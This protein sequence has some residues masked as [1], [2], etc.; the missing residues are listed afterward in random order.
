MKQSTD[1]QRFTQSI[2]SIAVV[3]DH[4]IA[5]YIDTFAITPQNII[6]REH[7]S[8]VGFFRIYDES[9]DGA[10]I[11]NFLTSVLK[12]AFYASTRRDTEKALELALAKINLALGELAQHNSAQWIGKVDGAICAFTQTTVCFSTCGSASIKL[13]RDDA[14]MEISTAPDATPDVLSTFNDI[15]CGPLKNEDVFIIASR[16]CGDVLSHDECQRACVRYSGKQREQFF[17]TALI[18]QTDGSCVHLVEITPARVEIARRDAAFDVNEENVTIPE[19]VFSATTFSEKPQQHSAQATA[20]TAP[21]A[22]HATATTP[23][24]IYLQGDEADTAQTP[25]GDILKEYTLQLRATLRRWTQSSRANI[26]TTYA[27]M[28]ARGA[29]HA[30]KT[31]AYTRTMSRKSF[32]IALA[33]ARRNAQKVRSTFTRT[34]IQHTDTD[35]EK[36]DTA[37]SRKNSTKTEYPKTTPT[38][39]Q[40]IALSQKNTTKLPSRQPRIKHSFTPHA[41]TQSTPAQ[42]DTTPQ[43]NLSALDHFFATTTNENDAPHTT[44]R[45]TNSAAITN[46]LGKITEHLGALVYATYMRIRIALRRIATTP[47]KPLLTK[48][49]PHPQRMIRTLRNLTLRQRIASLVIIAAIVLVPLALSHMTRKKSPTVVPVTTVAT[50]TPTENASITT[51]PTSTPIDRTHVIHK[52]ATTTTIISLRGELYAIAP[53]TITQITNAA[54]KRTFT[55]P[56]RYSDIAEAIA[57]DDLNLLFLRTTDNSIIS[58]TPLGAE[59]FV[60]NTITFPAGLTIDAMAAYRTYLYFFDSAANDIYRYPRVTGGFGAA[61]DWLGDDTTFSAPRAVAIDGTIYIANADGTIQSLFKRKKKAFPHINLQPA[62]VADSLFTS[63]EEAPLFI[64]DRATQRI[65]AVNKKNGAIVKNLTHTDF[66]TTQAFTV[67]ERLGI[68]SALLSDGTI[69]TYK[70]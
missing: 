16:E 3:R 39:P 41:T 65:I 31:I 17:R 23:G 28:H 50:E 48:V 5:P 44:A 68:I 1:K 34:E 56:K 69:A 55:L 26:A 57:M 20:K 37:P 59:K 11:A 15:A 61:V 42:T 40:P 32:L 62:L 10:Y 64:L 8:L 9:D 14:L 43:R 63:S 58:F 25:F 6:E 19:N 60:K 12:K 2:A 49:L 4:R 7:G 22:E 47:K 33:A 18:N 46:T 29:H 51:D 30:R 35:T 36:H 24:H 45:S 38:N 70:Y 52:D 66:A 67:N 27:A 54:T 21:S 13:F 53:R